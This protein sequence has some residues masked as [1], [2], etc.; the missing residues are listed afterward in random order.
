MQ[1]DFEAIL[2]Q[3]IADLERELAS[4]KVMRIDLEKICEAMRLKLAETEAQLELA[5]HD[6][7]IQ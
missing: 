2:E 1:S 3:R 7:P 6:R 4:E 5:S